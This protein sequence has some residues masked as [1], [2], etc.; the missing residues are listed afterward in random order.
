M[1]PD[2][3]PECGA[4]LWEESTYDD[5]VEIEIYQVCECGYKRCLWR[6]DG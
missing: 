4:T 3:C 5:H 6:I 1:P 2:K